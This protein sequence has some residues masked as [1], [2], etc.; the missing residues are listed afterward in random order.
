MFVKKQWQPTHPRLAI[1]QM[2]KC[3]FITLLKWMKYT[4][5]ST[6]A[7]YSLR[8]WDFKSLQGVPKSWQK[9]KAKNNF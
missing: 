9:L 3:F 4:N 5:R 2:L 7:Y 6:F 8:F 1:D